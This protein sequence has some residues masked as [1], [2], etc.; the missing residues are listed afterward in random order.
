MI[1]SACAITAWPPLGD[2]D[3][4]VLQVVLAGALDADQIVAICGVMVGRGH[5]AIESAVG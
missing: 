4:D 3:A 2:L 1:Q 5:V